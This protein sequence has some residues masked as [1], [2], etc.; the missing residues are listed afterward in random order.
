MLLKKGMRC[1]Y[2]PEVKILLPIKKIIKISRY[3]NSTTDRKYF[4]GIDI[5]TT[6]PIALDK[7]VL[8]GWTRVDCSYEDML[9]CRIKSSDSIHFLS[10]KK[11]KVYVIGGDVDTDLL[12]TCFFDFGS[13]AHIYI[14]TFD[15]EFIINTDNLKELKQ[16][17]IDVTK[18]E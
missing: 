10:G 1:F 14:D 13:E 5:Q 17:L 7:S 6:D 9:K 4:I 8:S 18:E 15:T 11:K 16:K 2:Y 12:I 3:F